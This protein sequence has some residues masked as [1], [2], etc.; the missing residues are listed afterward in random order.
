MNNIEKE[1]RRVLEVIASGKA[2]SDPEIRQW[3]GICNNLSNALC[4]VA[5]CKYMT[6]TSGMFDNLKRTASTWEHF[7]GNIDYPVPHPKGGDPEDA[8]AYHLDKD[9]MYNSDL[10]YAKLRFKLAQHLLDN[11]DFSFCYQ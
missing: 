7:S 10:P 5:T 3:V 1:L 6:I 9:L 2:E 8:Y 11:M 4:E